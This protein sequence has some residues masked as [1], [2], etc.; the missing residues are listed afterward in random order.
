MKI[1]KFRAVCIGIGICISGCG[2]ELPF[3]AEYI[4]PNQVI[5]TYQGKQYTLDRYGTPTQTPFTY[6][7]ED[8][9]DIDLTIDGQVYDVDSPYDRDRKKVKKT[10]KKKT[11][12][13]KSTANKSKR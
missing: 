12:K 11:V 3:E 5:V 2:P 4:S 9:G 6:R 13:K 10:T 7:F 1:S 8:D